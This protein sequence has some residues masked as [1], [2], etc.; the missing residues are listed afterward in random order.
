MVLIVAAM[1]EEY[2][3]LQKL[4]QNKR[5]QESN[6]VKHTLGLLK[7]K[8]VV[9]MLSGIGKVNASMNV[10]SIINEY[11]DIHYIVNIGSAGGIK[12]L[13][14]KQLDLVLATKVCQHDI[15]LHEF[16]HPYGALPGMPVY[17]ESALNDKIIAEIAQL[18]ITY[19]TGCIASGDQFVSQKEKIAFIT[20]HFDDVCAV[21]MEAGA[22]AQVAY[23]HKI[24]FVIIR[25]ISDVIDEED[26]NLQFHE[27]IIR[28]SSN[29]ALATE[30]IISVIQ[31]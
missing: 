17:Y 12:N 10:T 1:P 14:L 27:Y 21:E 22:I 3:A 8:E 7:D 13:G 18:D 26:S 31:D 4:M 25:S 15:D 5:E 28:A 2:E 23:M 30:K 19:H 11:D 16:D 6:N 29:A 9:L 20:N 24:P